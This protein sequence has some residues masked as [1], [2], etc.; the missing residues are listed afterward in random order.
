MKKLLLL[1][2]TAL[3][4]SVNAFAQS[5]WILKGDVNNDGSVSVTDVTMVIS[6]ILG[7]THDGFNKDAADVNG[8]GSISVTDVTMIINIILTKPVPTTPDYYVGWVTGENSSFANFR[9]LTGDQLLSYATGY[10]KSSQSSIT[11][12]VTAADIVGNRQIFFLM[13]R[14]SSAP[15]DGKFFGGL[16]EETLTASDFTNG[17]VFNAQRTDV[18]ISSITYHVAGM[19]LPYET[20]NYF[21]INF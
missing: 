6:H 15:T 5:S 20:G 14:D 1:S 7:Q 8:D 9:S 16:A 4:L 12:T 13:W 3:L 17:D 18:T 11:K 2:I 10:N 19:R 21:K